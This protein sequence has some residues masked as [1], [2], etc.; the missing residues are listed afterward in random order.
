MER[1]VAFATLAYL[2]VGLLSEA[3]AERIKHSTGG[4]SLNFPS[5]WA[6]D[7]KKGPYALT[8]SDGSSF[9][10]TPAQLPPD[11]S[12]KVAALIAQAAALATGL[13]SKEPATEFDLAG[14]GW[15]GRGFHCNNRIDGK[16]RRTQ[17]IGLIVKSGNTF[18]Q[19]FLFVPRQ[20][21]ATKSEQYHVLFKSLRFGS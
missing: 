21:W 16:S 15:N 5:G 13:C 12:I 7:K 19:F 10:A 4:Y 3:H 9:E 6:I 11:A 8:H 1:L 18:Y 14:P 20:D 17:T 2:G